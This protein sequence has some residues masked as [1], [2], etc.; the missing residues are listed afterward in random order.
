MIAAIV[1]VLDEAAQIGALL[2]ALVENPEV[3][4]VIVVDGG[5]R[6]DTPAIAAAS[7]RTRVIRS[8]RGRARQL[9]AGAV[10]SQAAVLWFLHADS[11]LPAGAGAAIVAALGAPEVV[12]G[13]FRFAIDGPGWPLRLV[14]FGTRCR[15]RLRRLPYGDQGLF[16]RRELFERLGRFP[17]QP[18]L[19]DLHFV[20]RLLRAGKI[21]LLPDELGTSARRWQRHGV[22]RVL[23]QH[24]TILWLDRLGV[25]PERLAARRAPR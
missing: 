23:W 3:S 24:Q 10:A 2:A 19:E 7:P 4:E 8:E 13:A 15:C 22:W 5:S 18:I 16:V 12:G 9:N 6:D 14:E 17:D 20:R 1:P 25:A 11:R 21:A